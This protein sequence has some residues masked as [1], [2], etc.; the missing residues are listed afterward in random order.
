MNRVGSLRYLAGAAAGRVLLIG[1][2][3][4][5]L[6]AVAV[7]GALVATGGVRPA[8]AAGGSIS[9]ATYQTSQVCHGGVCTKTSVPVSY[10]QVRGSGFTV[11]SPVIVEVIRMTNVTVARSYTT[12]FQGGKLVVNTNVRYCPPAASADVA[13]LFMVRAINLVTMTYSNGIVATVC[14]GSSL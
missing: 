12:I 7:L 5:A 6:L 10:M 4:R 9:L 13:D 3:G 11:G 1:T 14:P 8:S 2:P